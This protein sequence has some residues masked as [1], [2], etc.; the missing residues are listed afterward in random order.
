MGL[1]LPPDDPDN[2]LSKKTKTRSNRAKGRDSYDATVGNNLVEFFN[3]NVTPY[4]TEAGGP[5]FDLIPVE[6]QKDIMVNVARMH[7]QKEYDRIM[8]MVEILQRQAAEL[9]RRLEITDLVHAARY[10]FQVYH[11]QCYWLVSD[12]K[13]GG[14]RLVHQGP[15][16]WSTGAPAQYQYICR[17]K[18][19]GDYTWIEVD[20]NDNPVL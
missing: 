4:P 10:E 14:T 17:V 20:H 1:V 16:D 9:K 7:A 11:G 19:L 13:S 18:W 12:T 15:T 5:K 2:P 3:R 8:E 6:K